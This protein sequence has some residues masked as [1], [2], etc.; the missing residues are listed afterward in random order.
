[1]MGTM[2]NPTVASI[3][4]WYPATNMDTDISHVNGI[5]ATQA[6]GPETE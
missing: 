5:S 6:D 2:P 4:S 1:M 3:R